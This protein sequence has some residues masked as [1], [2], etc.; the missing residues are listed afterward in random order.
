MDTGSANI[1]NSAAAITATKEGRHMVVSQG[2]SE[3]GGQQ[4]RHTNARSI[5]PRCAAGLAAQH[6]SSTPPPPAGAPPAHRRRSIGSARLPA[7]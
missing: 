1:A 7:P 2:R 3:A 4:G 5:R 6:A